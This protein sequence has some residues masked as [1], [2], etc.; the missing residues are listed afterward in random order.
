MY[1]KTAAQLRHSVHQSI[2]NYPYNEASS[3]QATLQA[4]CKNSLNFV[5][6]LDILQTLYVHNGCVNTVN[7]NAS[8]TH[9]VSGSDDNHLVITE[10]KSG[11]VA[12][13]SKTQ[14]KRHIFS[15][16][17]MP[18]S[19]DQAV[20]SCSGE[21]LVIHTEFQ[22]PYSSEKCT[23]TTD[24]I[25]GEDS[26]IVNVFDCHTFGST[27]DVLPI[28]DAPRSFLSCG[29][30]ATVRCFD[31]RQSSSCSK[32]MCQK[33]IL[34][35]AP[36]A[37]TAMDVAPFNH[38]NVAI[39]CSDSIIRLYDRR[40]L[41]NTGSASLSSGST[42]PIKAFPIP[43]EYTRR[44]Y[45]PTCVKFNVNESE[46]LVSYSMEQIYLFD[47]KHPGYND[48]GLLKSG[49]YTPKMRREDD[50][51]PQMPRLR[52]RGDWSDT[53]PNSQAIAE[54]GFNRPNVGQARPP[55]EPGVLSRLSDEIFRMLNSP[56]RQMRQTSQATESNTD[57]TLNRNSNS[58]LPIRAQNTIYGNMIN[59]SDVANIS[60]KSGCLEIT[61]DA[62][63][64]QNENKDAITAG[65]GERFPIRNFN[66][67]KMAFSGH[68]NS[69]TMVKGACF[70][71]DDFIMS[72]SDCGHIFVWNRQTGKVVKTLLADNRVVNRVQPHPTLPY[73]LSSGIDYNVK[74]W[75]PIASDPHFDE[76]E[77]AGLIKSNEIMLVETR[78]TITVP[79]QIMI[80]ILASLHQ[81]RRLMHE[82]GSEARSRQ[83]GLSGNGAESPNSDI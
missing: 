65:D 56:S 60:V 53:G 49:C 34:I 44:H 17:F 43:M 6:R 73:L 82:A 16:R 45:R 40:M 18:H 62:K 42:I 79:A 22:I 10:A 67:V 70:W 5:Q 33:H 51:D 12:L 64:T 15:A 26:R 21:G 38:N 80:R 46:L 36:C 76:A 11:R 77:T 39:G 14:H 23:K 7:W 30:D 69:R 83:E 24:Y 59:E 66:Y 74:V 20:V 63:D 32:S 25:V 50:P 48:A 13:K 61:E 35:M 37:V 78:D 29:E 58:S 3:A 1:K 57:T 75:A 27:F 52:F 31:L 2:E 54:Q 4:S 55:L 41:A 68:R 47:L 9:I 81:Y 72:G 71:G 28:P 8:G 19:N